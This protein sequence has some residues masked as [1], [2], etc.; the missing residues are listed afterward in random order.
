MV[1][2]DTAGIAAPQGGGWRGFSRPAFPV[3]RLMVCRLYANDGAAAF[4]NYRVAPDAVEPCDPLAPAQDAE[5]AGQVDGDAGAVFREDAALQSPDAG[6]FGGGYQRGQQPPAHALAA[7]IRGDI[8]AV[9]GHAGIA[10]PGG[11]RGQGSPADD[12][13]AGVGAP[14]PGAGYQAADGEMAGVPGIPAGNRRFKG[15]VAGGDAGGVDGAYRRP[16]R[17]GH[18]SYD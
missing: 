10:G 5:P 2:G 12:A 6:G 9:F 15:G 3:C 7:Q 11:Y 8:D 14:V 17:R 4:H 16:V 18:R 1:T 13:A